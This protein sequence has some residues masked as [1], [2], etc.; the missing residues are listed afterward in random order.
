MVGLFCVRHLRRGRRS[1]I[2]PIIGAI[3]LIGAGEVL[4]PLGMISQA[5]VALLALLFAPDGFVGLFRSRRSK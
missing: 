1:I 4:R 3:F 2:G 5:L